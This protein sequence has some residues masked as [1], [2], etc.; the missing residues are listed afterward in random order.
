MRCWAIL[1][2]LF[3]TIHVQAL[4]SD[5]HGVILTK[6]EPMS[7]VLVYVANSKDKF[8]VSDNMGC[9]LISDVQ[10]QDTIIFSFIGFHELRVSVH[11]LQKNNQVIMTEKSVG[12]ND[13]MVF[14]SKEFSSDF[15]MKS[16]SQLEILISPMSQADPLNAVLS[17]VASTNTHESAKPSLRGSSMGYTMVYINGI[18]LFFPTKGN[19]VN[20]SIA[21]SSSM[22][23]AFVGSESIYASNSPIE[24]ENAAS[25]SVN[26]QLNTEVKDKKTFFLSSVGSSLSVAKNLNNGFWESYIS[27]TDLYPFIKMN[28]TKEINHYHSYDI[29]G[30]YNKTLKDSKYSFFS[31]YMKEDGDYPILYLNKEAGYLNK[32]SFFNNIVNYEYYYAGFKLKADFSY[33]H[34]KTNVKYYDLAMT[35][36]CN[37]LY[38]AIS[39]SQFINEQLQF[40]LGVNSIVSNFKTVSNYT[41][42]WV[43]TEK[44]R[45]MQLTPYA[46]VKFI[47]GDYSAL[48][49]A[50]YS[51]AK[52]NKPVF[53]ANISLK[54]TNACHKVLLSAAS[55]SMY[56]YN[57]SMLQRYSKM[58]CRQF[59]IEY[60]YQKNG[61]NGHVALYLKDEEGVSKRAPMRGAYKKYIFG[62]EASLKIQ[63]LKNVSWSISNIYLNTYYSFSGRKYKGEDKLNY[64]IKSTLNYENPKF[65]NIALLLWNRPGTYYTPVEYATFDSKY[66]Y[67]IPIYSK[68]INSAQYKRYL[69]LSVNI[70]KDVSFSFAKASVFLCFTNL[71]NEKNHSAIYYNEDYSKSYMQS[72]MGRTFFVG[73]VFHFN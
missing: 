49:G 60:D 35:E 52:G 69:N 54:Y 3:A 17:T 62:V 58:W 41:E 4:S 32:S 70:S 34:L 72:Y 22:N 57:E 20:N 50:K 38:G 42:D 46:S 11:D 39:Y 44:G 65:L 66:N 12:I 61:L 71:F 67:Y 28:K 25:G 24:F 5:V 37:Y 2:V 31:S 14:R 73:C 13:V 33:S 1:V 68:Q 18:P 7:G 27:Y 16:Y 45:M 15:P 36:Y 51:F 55:L 8:A 23:T 47:L 40:K 9:F 53:N 63:L 56:N 29:G 10:E 26:M 59:C 48:L 64:F 30:R 6:G 19:Y 21:S 43:G